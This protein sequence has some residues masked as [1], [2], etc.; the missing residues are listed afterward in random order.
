MHEPQRTIQ[1]RPTAVPE[2]LLAIFAHPDDETLLIGGTLAACA[3]AGVQ[4]MI[5][6]ATR[7]EQGPIAAPGLA[8]RKTLGAVREAELRKAARVLGGAVVECLGYPDGELGSINTRGLQR[9]LGDHMRNWQPHAVITF[10]P[11]GLYWHPDHVAIHRCTLG[12]WRSLARDGIKP[13]LFYASLPKGWVRQLV[14]QMGT[15]GLPANLW[16]LRPDDFGVPGETITTILDVRLYVRQ[17]LNA[18]RC[19]RTQLASDHLFSRLP[20]DLAREYLGR[21]YFSRLYPRRRGNDW[22]TQIVGSGGQ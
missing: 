17:K 10:G 22:L 14:A 15:R 9:E 6:C 12:A 3:A 21:E 19:H 20:P 1:G 8:T 11:E 5:V 4:T 7:G 16:G 2:R 18:L 13:Q